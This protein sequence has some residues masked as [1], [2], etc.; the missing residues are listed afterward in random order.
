META[1]AFPRAA[2]P[3]PR[4]RAAGPARLPHRPPTVAAA[5]AAAAILARAGGP[6]LPG[7]TCAAP[8]LPSGAL[9]PGFGRRPSPPSPSAGSGGPRSPQR[10]GTAPDGPVRRLT[11]RGG[12]R[13]RGHELHLRPNCSPAFR[14]CPQHMGFFS[15]STRY[16]HP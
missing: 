14:P 16:L 10:P 5:A 7:G 9:P 8:A 15:S 12:R 13:S 11:P 3:G 4:L 2:R 6:C 1:P